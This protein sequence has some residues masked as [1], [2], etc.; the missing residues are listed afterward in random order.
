MKLEMSDKKMQKDLKKMLNNNTPQVSVYIII[1]EQTTIGPKYPEKSKVHSE[2]QE[3]R[4]TVA[5]YHV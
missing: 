2:I 3:F 4:C 5:E 1:G